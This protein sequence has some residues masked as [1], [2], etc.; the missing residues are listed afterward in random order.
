MIMYMIMIMSI[1]TIR[2]ILVIMNTLCHPKD[3]HDEE[4]D[5]DHHHDHDEHD[6]YDDDDGDEQLVYMVQTGELTA[7]H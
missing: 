5:D 4:F 1:T 3:N 6:E 7:V 2:L